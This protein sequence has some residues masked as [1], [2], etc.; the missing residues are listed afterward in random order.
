M[1]I[2]CPSCSAS[3][4]VK[5]EALGAQGRTV[6]CARCKTTWFAA[7]AAPEAPK[8]IAPEALEALVEQA[9]SF[10]S[11]T[12][13]APVIDAASA[14][15]IPIPIISADDRA[16][17]EALGEGPAVLVAALEGRPLD[18]A[19]HGIAPADL[20]PA[21]PRRKTVHRPE[22]QPRRSGMRMPRAAVLC[23]VLVAT[24]VLG[25]MG[26][27][28]VVRAAPETASIYAAIGFPVNLRGL[29]FQNVVV[30]QETQDGVQVL[31]I[32]GEVENVA[33]RAIELPRVRLAVIGADGNEIYSW[34]TLLPRSILYPRE[35][36]PFK[37]RLASPPP[38]G[39]QIMVRFLT[40]SDLVAGLR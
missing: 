3:F 24:L 9:E 29:D 20:P 1:R 40:R 32:E 12:Q 23:I 38:A 16:D 14:S 28:S 26:R 19:E 6:R 27:N 33:G 22:Q 4:E 11:E 39:K 7:A 2:D 21:R 15:E 5:A 34:T 8:I 25:V 37:S 36:V 10:V 17:H 31:M 18:E 30:R 13:E 35:R